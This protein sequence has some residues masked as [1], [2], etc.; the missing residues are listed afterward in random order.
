MEA[1]ADKRIGDV[2]AVPCQK[3]IHT[4]NSSG[5][6]MKC[7]ASC[8]ERQ[9]AAFNQLA[10]ESFDFLVEVEKREPGKQSE[11]FQTLRSLALGDFV[12]HELGREKIELAPLAVPPF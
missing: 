6:Q 2:L 10:G 4:V 1:V 8:G 5:G 12:Q 3:E 9:N 7:I 11:A